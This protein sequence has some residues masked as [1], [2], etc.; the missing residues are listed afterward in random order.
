MIKAIL[1]E[2]EINAQQVFEKMLHLIAPDFILVEKFTSIAATAKF[3]KN[4]TIDVAFLDIE[5]D[6][7][8][9]FE[10][11]NQL[12]KIN[13]EIVF[14]TAFNE[15]AI[16][17]IKVNAQ[18]YLL[19]PI[20]PEELKFAIEKVKNTINIR[21]V[22]HLFADKVILKTATEIII[23]PIASIIRLEANGAYTNFI[24]ENKI[25]LVSKNIKYYESILPENGFIRSH[26][27][28]LIAISKIS[29]ILPD[30]ILLIN[31]DIIP[32]SHRKKALIN[33]I[34]K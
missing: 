30:S 10:L 28:H 7:G 25:I 32:I 20:D 5:V 26:Q 15:Y 34:I 14:T 27:S 22:N 33:K 8:N 16:K 21:E 2:D 23:L 19:K 31:G 17:A 12:E 9:S 3:L 13:F 18:D 4:H 11:L 6:D 24:T 29:S 1:L